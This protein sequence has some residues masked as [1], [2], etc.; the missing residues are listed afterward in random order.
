[1]LSDR[2]RAVKTDGL[3]TVKTCMHARHTLLGNENSLL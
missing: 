3:R 1:M 2:L